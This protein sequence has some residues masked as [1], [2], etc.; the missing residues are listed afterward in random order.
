MV[1]IICD[2]CGEPIR[3][4]YTAINHEFM[5]IGDVEEKQLCHHCTAKLIHWIK[6]EPEEESYDGNYPRITF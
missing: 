2:K 5:Q 1:Q 3:G 4:P 6:G